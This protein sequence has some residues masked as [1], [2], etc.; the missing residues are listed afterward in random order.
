[1]FRTGEA[2][3]LLLIITMQTETKTGGTLQKFLTDTVAEHGQTPKK[4]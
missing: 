4:A 2:S 1:M 3:F